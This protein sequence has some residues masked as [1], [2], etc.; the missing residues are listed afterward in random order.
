MIEKR[1]EGLNQVIKH[2]IGR[3]ELYSHPHFYTFFGMSQHVP[4]LV[5]N[6]PIPISKISN[7]ASMSYRDAF[8]SVEDDWAFTA[9]HSVFVANRVDS[10]FSNFFSKKKNLAKMAQVTSANEKAV[11]L[12]EFLKR[13]HRDEV[14]EAGLSTTQSKSKNKGKEL[15]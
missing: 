11:G 8:I 12:V 13:I 15:T 3:E 4:F 9:S 1:K 10:Y 14:L 5:I 6:H 2:L 7:G